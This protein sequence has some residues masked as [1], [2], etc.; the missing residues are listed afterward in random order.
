LI[1]AILRKEPDV[2]KYY[3][4]NKKK[5]DK[6]QKVPNGVER[7]NFASS[8]VASTLLEL[9]DAEIA[10]YNYRRIR[11]YFNKENT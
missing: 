3:G 2:M 1:L 9:L 7:H 6:F 10:H 11:D 5:I 8:R 4:F